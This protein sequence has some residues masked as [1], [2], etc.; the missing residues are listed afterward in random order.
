M[1]LKKHIPS[2][3]KQIVVFVFLFLNCFLTATSFGNVSL[4]SEKQY[5]SSG[6]LSQ[7]HNK[8]DTDDNRCSKYPDAQ[9]E[10]HLSLRSKPR[11][12]HLSN[13]IFYY[14]LVAGNINKEDSSNL[15]ESSS[16]LVRPAY[17]MFLSLYKLF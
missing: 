4:E 15:I 13:T 10:Y 16:F 7:N 9:Q 11:A 2:H 14:S 1:S 8:A 12:A 6:Y 3:Y 17:Y 5:E